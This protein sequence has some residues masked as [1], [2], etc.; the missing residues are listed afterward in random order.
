MHAV[1]Y[2]DNIVWCWCIQQSVQPESKVELR[3][4]LPD[5]KV[6]IVKVAKNSTTD[7][8]YQVSGHAMSVALYQL[9]CIHIDTSTCPGTRVWVVVNMKMVEKMVKAPIVSIALSQLCD[10]RVGAHLHLHGPEPTVSCRHSSVMWV[11]GHTSPTYCHYS[12]LLGRYK[13]ILLG[14]RGTCV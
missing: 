5:R 4:M 3:V 7:D 13:I 1:V 9:G 8:V 12:Q 14:D 6:S 10:L 2:F 11:V